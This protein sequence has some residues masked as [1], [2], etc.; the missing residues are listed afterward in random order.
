MATA[1][2]RSLRRRDR[3]AWMAAAA[4]MPVM[5]G[6]AYLQWRGWALGSNASYDAYK[7]F[8]VFYPVLLSGFCGWLHGL[9]A[10]WG[11]RLAAVGMLVAVTL[12]NGYAVSRLAQRMSY[13][14]LKVGPSLVDLQRVEQMSEVASVN[15]RILDMWD[16][17]WANQ[18]LLRKPQY[19]ETHSYEGRLNTPL[20]GEWDL[21]GGLIQARLP[22]GD[23]ITIND[24]FGLVRCESPLHIR[25]K[26]GEGWHG[27][28]TLH[29]RR[30]VRWNWS[31]PFGEII[32]QTDGDRA[33][34]VR[35]HLMAR[36]LRPGEIQLWI[37][38]EQRHIVTVGRDKAWVVTPVFRIPAGLSVIALQPSHFSQELEGADAR[39]L[40][41]AA[42]GIVVEVLSEHSPAP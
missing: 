40:C 23:V 41:L 36:A 31:Q 34:D 19:F 9:T 4:V 26:W 7:L 25:A 17:L 38:G 42:Y 8:A 6:Y 13:A 10:G 3:S 27:I 24:E 35:L 2:L 33:L 21:N 11:W 1:W 16:R 32:I 39:K 5:T 20:R 22:G 29:A 30:K 28:E 37:N 12:G 15:L 18:F 14:P